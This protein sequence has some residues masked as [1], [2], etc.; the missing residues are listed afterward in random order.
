MATTHSILDRILEPLTECLTP[1]VARRVVAFR[2][3]EQTQQRLDEL[4][5]R[6]NEG[7]LSVA[8]QAEYRSYIE[9]IDLVS[10]LQAKAQALL[11]KQADQ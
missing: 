7:L 11:N 4:A 5:E 2:A 8:E 10:I 6:A 3:D 9:A 1:E